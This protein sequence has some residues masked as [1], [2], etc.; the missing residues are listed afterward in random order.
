MDPR[1]SGRHG[2][3]FGEPARP[4]DTGIVKVGAEMSLAGQTLMTV[5]AENMA[6]E[7]Y[8]IAD[9]YAGNSLPDRLNGAGYL[10]AENLR[11]LDPLRGP[12]NPMK[13][14]QIGAADSGGL[15]PYLDFIRRGLR[16][17]QLLAQLDAAFCGSH[18]ANSQHRS[19]APRPFARI[20]GRA[21][22]GF[23]ATR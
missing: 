4:V 20:G 9:A 11:K 23:R 3:V 7:A 18:L 13:N 12:W 6:F 22:A 8:Q 17:R 14:V 5:A 16:Y 10:M 15:D 19:G 2:D 21:N 1:N